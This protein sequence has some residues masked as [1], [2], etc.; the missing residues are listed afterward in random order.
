MPG[1]TFEDF[2]RIVRSALSD[3]FAS[4]DARIR[5]GSL[6]PPA[7]CALLYPS[8]VLFTKTATHHVFELFGAREQPGEL[9]VKDNSK[10]K[11]LNRLVG[12][13]DPVDSTIYL[14]GTPEAQPTN[15]LIAFEDMT[16]GNGSHLF[17]D[18]PRLVAS[19][20]LRPPATLVSFREAAESFMAINAECI[21]TPMFSRVLVTSGYESFVR[22]RYTNLLMGESIDADEAELRK[23][24]AR[25][26]S[27]FPPRGVQIASS[28]HYA[29]L[30][31]MAS[32]T[33]L[34]LQGVKE[35][36]ITEFVE[37]HDKIIRRAFGAEVVFYQKKLAWR[38]GNS[39]PTE[40]SIQ[41]DVILRTT[42]GEWIILD[43]KLPLLGKKLTARGHSRRK[44]AEPVGEGVEQLANYEEYFTFEKN[45]QEAFTVLGDCPLDPQLVLVIGSSENFNPVEIR[46][47]KRS[48][49]PVEILDYDTLIYL[50]AAQT[51][52]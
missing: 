18:D 29:D 35:T 40:E 15:M 36:T 19:D 16:L 6:T 17:A 28:E 52:A 9:A 8:T 20:A 14:I 10:I 32:F 34:Y 24:L 37:A 25:V 31:L 47:A 49:R 38:E 42:D 43:F 33:T 41:P 51:E 23:D 2:K 50:F 7:N 48:R 11:T 45:R 39:D 22:P 21:R 46:E 12:G 5:E 26:L 1:L 3:Y 30:L 13:F 44:L 4:I 27:E